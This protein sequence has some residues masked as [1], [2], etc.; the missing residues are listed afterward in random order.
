[1][2]KESYKP[3]EEIELSSTLSIDAS[4][5]PQAKSLSESDEKILG[6]SDRN[7]VSCI[8]WNSTGGCIAVSY[9]R[10]LHE[11]MCSHHSEV[12]VW[13]LFTKSFSPSK[14]NV[15]LDSPVFF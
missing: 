10:K 12:A 6:I 7:I 14:P 11:E 13:S 1:M 3:N 8:S 5:H 15:I 4:L 2:N 9:C